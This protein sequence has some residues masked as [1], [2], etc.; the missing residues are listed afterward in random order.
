V[1]PSE[2]LSTDPRSGIVRR[3]HIHRSSLE[4]HLRQ[5]FRAARINKHA[6][7]HTFRHSFATHLLENGTDIRT[8]QTLLGHKD[9]KT[10]MI[11]THVM[12]DRYRTTKSPVD[13]LIRMIQREKQIQQEISPTNGNLLNHKHAVSTTAE[14]GEAAAPIEQ[15][16]KNLVAMPQLKR[17]LAFKFF[18]LRFAVSFQQ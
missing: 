5:A 17:E 6:T 16:A 18:G 9:V 10:T 1:F 2:G 8:V 12:K 11:Y 14:T 4:R 3:H 15:Q 7:A 13:E